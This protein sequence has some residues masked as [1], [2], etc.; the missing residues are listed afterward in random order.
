MSFAV[1]NTHAS[2]SK[3]SV[4]NGDLSFF[5][6][7][8]RVLPFEVGDVAQTLSCQQIGNHV[9]HGFGEAVT[10]WYMD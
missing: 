9:S 5:S 7:T 2:Q 1:V 10:K 3:M 4:L 6:S 8:S